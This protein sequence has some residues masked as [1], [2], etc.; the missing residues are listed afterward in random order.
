MKTPFRFLLLLVI[1]IGCARQPSLPRDSKYNVTSNLNDSTWYGTGKLLR[2][3]KSEDEAKQ[4]RTGNLIVFTDIDYL[5][6]AGGPNPNTENGCTDPECTR[7]Q[8]LAI[9][10][11]PLKKGKHSIAKIDASGAVLNESTSLSYIGN[12]GGLIKLYTREKGKPGWIRISRID[13]ATGTIEGS[14]DIWLRHDRR[15]DDVSKKLPETAHFSKGLFRIK[16][17]DVVER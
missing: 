2:F 7:T 16:V 11:I 9:Y 6:I 14:F 8:S 15:R 3:G 12:A 5:G 13:R 4:A 1:C 10:K 17:T